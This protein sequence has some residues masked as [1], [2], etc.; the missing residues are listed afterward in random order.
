[1]IRRRDGIHAYQFA[2]VVD[3]AWQ[4]IT[5]VV[6]GADLLQ[7]TGW[8]VTIATGLKLPVP[9]FLH[10][11]VVVEADGS[12]LAKSRRSM[13]LDSLD[14]LQALE[15]GLS[16]LCPGLVP[17]GGSVTALLEWGLGNFDSR[18]LEGRQ[19]TRFS[20]DSFGSSRGL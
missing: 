7:S 16:I 15:L 1:V 17:E 6:R 8:Q 4:G 9:R 3:D 2:V 11:P 20:E 14:P 19:E 10:L 5:D 13:A 12:K 18:R